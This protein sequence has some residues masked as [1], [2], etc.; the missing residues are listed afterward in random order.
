MVIIIDLDLK[1][2]GRFFCLCL[3]DLG[4]GRQGIADGLAA[5]AIET[6]CLWCVLFWVRLL[7]MSSMYAEYRVK[8]L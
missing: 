7:A 1:A 4:R 2:N 3:I 8:E 6:H 5:S